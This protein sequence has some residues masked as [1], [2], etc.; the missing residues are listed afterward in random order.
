MWSKAARQGSSYVEPGGL[1]NKENSLATQKAYKAGR[2]SPGFKE[3]VAQLENRFPE[4]LTRAL[5]KVSTKVH[6]GPPSEYLK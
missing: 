6:T 2:E 5:S 4:S 3:L 1:E